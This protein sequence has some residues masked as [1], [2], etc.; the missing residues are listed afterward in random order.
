[1]WSDQEISAYCEL[2]CWKNRVATLQKPERVSTKLQTLGS[3]DDVYAS[4]TQPTGV[5]RSGREHK[6]AKFK[7]EIVT[8]RPSTSREIDNG[9][10]HEQM[11]N[12]PHINSLY[13]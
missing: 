6:Q 10:F 2:V 1:M 5:R 4:E 13:F 3:A 8:L 9:I 12:D 11:E 7:G